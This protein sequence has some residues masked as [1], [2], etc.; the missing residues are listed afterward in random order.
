MIAMQW[1]VQCRLEIAKSKRREVYTKSIV[2]LSL[3]DILYS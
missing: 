2:N 3:Y 1:D